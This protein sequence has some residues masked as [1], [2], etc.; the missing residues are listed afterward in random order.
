VSRY[1]LLDPGEFSEVVLGWD[2]GTAGFFVQCFGPDEDEDDGGPVFARAG[3]TLA[4]LV[5]ALAERGL[6]LSGLA[7]RVL[8]SDRYGGRVFLRRGDY[9][10]L[11]K[12]P[13]IIVERLVTM[14]KVRMDNG[15]EELCPVDELEPDWIAAGIV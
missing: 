15:D 13:C 7:Q 2:P 10:L 11:R 3:L 4:E 6:A 5:A 1:T 9:A 12:A 8:E 14:A